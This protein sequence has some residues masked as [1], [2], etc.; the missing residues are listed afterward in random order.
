MVIEI[1]PLVLLYELSV[2][3]ATLLGHGATRDDREP[4]PTLAG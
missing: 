1:I 3:L 4:E 2:L